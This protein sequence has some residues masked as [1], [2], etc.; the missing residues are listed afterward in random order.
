MTIS[1]ST[2]VE[3]SFKQQ[4]VKSTSCLAY[5]DMKLAP[6]PNY[7]TIGCPFSNETRKKSNISINTYS[8]KSALCTIFL[9]FTTY[10]LMF[11]LIFFIM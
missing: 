1:H 2:R 4:Q 3:D 6:N 8:I 11:V 9:Y 10:F 7:L 5:G